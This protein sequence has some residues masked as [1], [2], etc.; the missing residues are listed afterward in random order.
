AKTF[1]IIIIGDSNVGK[2]CLAYRLC[3]GKFPERT[4]TTIGVD[5]WEKSLELNGEF[6]KLQLWDTA[7]QERFRKSM[8]CH[9]YRNVN[10]V[11]FMYDITRKCSFEALTT[12]IVEYRHHAYSGDVPKILIGNKCDLGLER[13]VSSN[14]ARKF[15]DSHNMPLWE[16]SIK[17]DAELEQ[18]EAIFLTLTHKLLKHK[19]L[20]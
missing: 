18:I 4:E 12:W 1:K 10:A 15:A 13:T 11:V 7:G 2:T 9:Y 6:V 3:T 8:V 19:P 14:I 20:M 16:I 17:N 5:F